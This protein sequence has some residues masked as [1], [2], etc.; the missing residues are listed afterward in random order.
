MFQLKEGLIL[1]SNIKAYFRPLD[2]PQEVKEHKEEILLHIGDYPLFWYPYL[3]RVIKKVK[4]DILIHTGDLVDNLKAGRIEAHI[5]PYKKHALKLIKFMEKHVKEVYIVPGNND[6]ESYII[7]ESKKSKIIP[8]NTTL[9]IRDFSCLLCHRVMDINGEADYYFYGHG[10]TG[11]T[12]T[13]KEGN[14]YYSNAFFANS[15]LFLQSGK[16]MQ[17]TKHPKRSY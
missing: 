12:H 16:M 13:F 5:K 11:D 3:K 17:L 15:V 4:P 6:I 14:K 1:I 7:K 9:K 2:L 10:P 8:F